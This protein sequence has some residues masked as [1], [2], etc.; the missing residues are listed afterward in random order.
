MLGVPPAPPSPS[1]VSDIVAT[2]DPVRRNYRITVGYWRIALAMRERLPGGATWCAFGTWA[3]RQAGSSIRKEDVERAVARRLQAKLERLSVLREAQQLLRLPEMRLPR[4]VGAL[5]QGLPGIDRTAHALATGNALI[6]RE[7]GREFSRYLAHGDAGFS[8]DLRPGPPP[9]GQDLL[10]SAFAHYAAAERSSDHA[11]R[12][13]RVFL[14][15]VQIALHEQTAAQP[16]I[17]EAM[18]AAL[19]DIADTRRIVVARLDRLAAEGPLGGLHTGIGRRVFN[20]L[21]DEVSEALREVV[22]L[23]I[24]ERLMS[25]EMP[26]GQLLRLGSDIAALFP[27]SLSTITDSALASQ[28]TELDLTP[29]TTRGSGTLDWSNLSDRMHFLTDF[30]RCYHEDAALFDPPFSATDLVAIEAGGRP[31]RN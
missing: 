18:D 11:G 10:R 31:D 17:R 12:A 14:A 29:E 15:N 20:A 1:Q 26:D 9:D 21:A 16:L 23:V 25:I 8:D 2:V 13:Q 24:T 6:F 3:S 5:S 30:F 22:R 27:A 19:M 4:L 7:M 28:L